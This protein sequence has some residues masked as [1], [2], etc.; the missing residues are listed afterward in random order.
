MD[1]FN[2]E[3]WQQLRQIQRH[4]QGVNDHAANEV[5][6]AST[7]LCFKADAAQFRRLPNGRVRCSLAIPT[8]STRARYRRPRHSRHLALSRPP[9]DH[10]NRSLFGIDAQSIHEFFERLSMV[11]SYL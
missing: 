1:R 9:L 6:L 5:L 8:A 10:V 7:M 11:G 3:A 4:L 2:H